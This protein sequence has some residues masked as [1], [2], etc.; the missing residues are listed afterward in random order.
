MKLSG[1]SYRIIQTS[2]RILEVKRTVIC[3][4]AIVS[5]HYGIAMPEFM[6]KHYI[7]LRVIWLIV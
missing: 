3:L 2:D 1:W 4:F 7:R 6:P 5:L